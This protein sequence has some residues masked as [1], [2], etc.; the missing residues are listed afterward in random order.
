MTM[1][2]VRSDMSARRAI[3]PINILYDDVFENTPCIDFMFHLGFSQNVFTCFDLWFC[4]Y[5]CLFV[6]FCFVF[7][8]QKS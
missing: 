4:L 1:M 2:M 3:P 6:L 8:L 7:Q 5:V